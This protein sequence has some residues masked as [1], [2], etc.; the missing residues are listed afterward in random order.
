MRD[1]KFGQDQGNAFYKELQAA[2]QN[3]FEQNNLSRAGSGLMTFKIALYFASVLFFYVLMLKVNS[4]G[5]FYLCYLSMGLA[6]LLTAF[7]VSHDAAHGVAVKSKFWNKVLFELSFHLQGNNAYVWGK[8]HNESHHLYTN[9]EGS[10]I[11][12]LHNPLIRM[13]DTQAL[14]PFHRFQHLYAPFLYLLYSLNW[15]FFRETLMVFNIS[16]RTIRV[17]MP[18]AEAFKLV[19]CKLAY[20]GYM[21]V[22]PVFWLPFGYTRPFGVFIE[23]FYGIHHFY[24]S[25]GRF[26]SFR[27]CGAPQSRRFGLCEHELA[28]AT[29]ENFRGL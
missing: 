7:N 5:G 9:I 13:T 14:R 8:Y 12:V 26:P 21:I 16:S 11:D 29:N 3:Y 6:V 18:P 17:E 2:V 24:G 10:D 23:S 4:L 27:L 20:I 28:Y 15:F 1:L 19:I 22:L 25:F